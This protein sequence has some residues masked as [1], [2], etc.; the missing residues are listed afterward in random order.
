MGRTL[1]A[2]GSRRVC[3]SICL[4]VCLSSVCVCAI[5]PCAFLH[6]G[7]ELNNESCNATTA[8]HSTTAKLARFLL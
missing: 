3:L 8:Q 5:L 2:Y 4:S 6:D 7:N 1:E